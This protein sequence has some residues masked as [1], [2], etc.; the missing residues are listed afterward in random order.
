MKNKYKLLFYAFLILIPV[1]VLAC[2]VSKKAIDKNNYINQDKIK[3]YIKSKDEVVTM[4]MEDYIK[5]VVAAEMPAEFESEALKAQAIAART[6]T[7]MH[8]NKYPGLN[9]HKGGDI[10]TDATH[11]QAYRSIEDLKTVWGNNNY[12]KYYTKISKSVTD[13]EGIV[14]VYNKELINPLFHS[15]SGGR[16]ENSE[17]VFIES[18][19]YLRSVVSPGEESAPRFRGNISLSFND[20]KKALLK[21]EPSLKLNNKQGSIK[22]IEKTQSGRVKRIQ[23]GN[24]IFNGK[25]IRN[26]FSLNSTNFNIKLNKNYILIETIGYGHGVGM[27]QFGA[28]YLASIGKNYIDILKYYYRGVELENNKDIK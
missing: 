2:N 18:L 25:D 20:F 11:C 16:T 28:N 8:K 17:D 10:C 27:S 22:I 15:T 6:Y 13:T 5:G 12:S 21:I 24:K 26:V 1:L 4:N 3:V 23:I 9:E 7:I 19:P 14:L